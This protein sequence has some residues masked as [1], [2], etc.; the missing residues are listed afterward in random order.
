MFKLG[1]WVVECLEDHL[2]V[3][4]VEPQEKT[5]GGIFIPQSV[6]ERPNE[7]IVRA[8]GTGSYSS[9]SGIFRPMPVQVGDRVLFGKFSGTT[10]VVEGVTYLMLRQSDLIARLV[11]ESTEEST[12]ES[13]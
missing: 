7:G 4:P 9:L 5:K 13:E 11:G 1:E 10:L 6:S 3:E 12:G 8:H 2:L